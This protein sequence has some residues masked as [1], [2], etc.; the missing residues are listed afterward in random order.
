MIKKAFGVINHCNRETPL[1]QSTILHFCDRCHSTVNILPTPRSTGVVILWHFVDKCENMK[2]IDIY[3]YN[4]NGPR[5]NTLSF[6][7]INKNW[8]GT[9]T[10][11]IA[12]HF[13]ISFTYAKYIIKQSF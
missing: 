12:S 9:N 2:H 6:I 3:F 8:T 11:D 4:G 1:K 7:L 13:L 5:Q 10:H